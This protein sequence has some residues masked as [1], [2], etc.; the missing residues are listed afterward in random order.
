MWLGP[1]CYTHILVC[2]LIQLNA[3]SEDVLKTLQVNV[4]SSSALVGVY[5]Y[6]IVI[7][8]GY[9]YGP[10]LASHTL[11]PRY[12]SDMMTQNCA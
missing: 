12:I 7:K 6:K 11:F 4:S 10:E 5:K 8:D 2:M 3:K 1:L 9:C